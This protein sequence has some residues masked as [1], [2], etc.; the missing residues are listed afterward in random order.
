[1]LVSL[2]QSWRRGTKCTVNCKPIG[3][4]FD[5]QWR[6]C[7]IYLKCIFPFLRSGVKARDGEFVSPELDGK[8]GT[9]C[10]NIKFP[11][12]TLLCA[13]CSVKLIFF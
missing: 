7:N 1:M 9:E 5:P 3:R 10:L 4:G 8:W 2:G 11:L 13:G 6:K 12:P